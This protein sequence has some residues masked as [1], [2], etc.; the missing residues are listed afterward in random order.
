MNTHFRN[1]YTGS[2]DFQAFPVVSQ[3]YY[4]QVLLLDLV[5]V[6]LCFLDTL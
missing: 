4:A 2:T 6:E 3:T 5:W 1:L